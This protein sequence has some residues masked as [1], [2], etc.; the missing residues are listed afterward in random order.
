MLQAMN[1]LF[2]VILDYFVPILKF[3]INGIIYNVP[4]KSDFFHVLAIL[5][6]FFMISNNYNLLS[7]IFPSERKHMC[8]FKITTKAK[9]TDIWNYCI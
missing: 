4:F 7:F 5:E 1:D 3:H 6:Q 2:S 8:V 9:M